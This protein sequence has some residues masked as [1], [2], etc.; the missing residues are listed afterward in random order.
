MCLPHTW[1]KLKQ[2]PTVAHEPTDFA[3]SSLISSLVDISLH[4][5][6]GFVCSI[7]FN[8]NSFSNCK[9]IP[10]DLI[11]NALCA[12]WTLFLLGTHTSEFP[13]NVSIFDLW[14]ETIN[15]KSFSIALY[16]SKI[17]GSAL[18]VLFYFIYRMSKDDGQIMWMYWQFICEAWW[19]QCY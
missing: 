3:H 16:Y 2:W 13:S 5:E 7:P 8:R 9:F 1:I 17:H 6:Y 10:F 15:A 18:F 14:F 4:I 19:V 11:L 12:V